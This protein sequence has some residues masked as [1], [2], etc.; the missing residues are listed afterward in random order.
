MPQAAHDL[1]RNPSPLE[2][3]VWPK[4]LPRYRRVV[5]PVPQ[6]AAV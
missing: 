1:H 4:T 3:D 6:A 5:Y 2:Y